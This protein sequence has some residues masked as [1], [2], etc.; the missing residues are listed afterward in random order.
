MLRWLSKLLPR[1][2]RM[3]GRVQGAARGAGRGLREPSR[4]EGGGDG[5][6]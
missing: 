4:R 6:I 1:V 3:A 2:G 5:T